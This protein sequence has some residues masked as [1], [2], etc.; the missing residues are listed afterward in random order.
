LKYTGFFTAYFILP[1]VP[2]VL[3]LIWTKRDHLFRKIKRL[4]ISGHI[5]E[6]IAPYTCL[7]ICIIYTGYVIWV[8]GDYMAMYR[9]FV[10]ILPLIYILVGRVIYSPLSYKTVSVRVLIILLIIF[11]FAATLIQSTPLETALFR[12]PPQLHGSYQGV[13]TERWHSSRLSLIGDFFN[14]YKTDSDESLLTTS[15]GAVSYYADMKIY[16][17]HGLVDSRIAHMKHKNIGKG[18]PGHE[19]GDVFYLL[20]KN[21]TYIMIG[22]DLTQEPL[23][24]VKYGPEISDILQ[25][26]YK[27][28][29]VWL[30]DEKNDEEGYFSFLELREKYPS[31]DVP[32]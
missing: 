1:L 18:F 4:R 24:D 17:T 5:K 9:F 22:K 12:E 20:S 14:R 16:G 6:N 11:A 21:P 25:E 29:N 7:L 28:S 10:P 13:L 23:L 15:I 2:L 27:I 3:L 8:G 26:K 30:V 32:K 31:E 19:K